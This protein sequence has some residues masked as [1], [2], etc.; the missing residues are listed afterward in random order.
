M[1]ADVT[2]LTC[3]KIFKNYNISHLFLIEGRSGHVNHGCLPMSLLPISYSAIF[4]QPYVKAQMKR[5]KH[6]QAAK[7]GR[8]GM[9]IKNTDHDNNYDR[10]LYEHA[11]LRRTETSSALLHG[12]QPKTRMSPYSL[13]K[14]HKCREAIVTRD[15]GLR[16]SWLADSY[17]S[18]S[19]T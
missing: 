10:V 2:V 11:L 13:S 18:I 15:S 5:H 17:I 16:Y 3:K 19:N 12:V 6:T 8:S 14:N 4:V 9:V 1:L 7:P